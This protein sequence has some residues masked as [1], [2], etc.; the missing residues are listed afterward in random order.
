MNC[1]SFAYISYKREIVENGLKRKLMLVLAFVAVLGVIAISQKLSEYVASTQMKSEEIFV[2]VDAGHGAEDPGKIGINNVLE[3][4]IN[5]Q[6][7]KKVQYYLKKE[8][9]GVIMTREDDQGLYDNTVSNKKAA[10][11]K[12]RVNLINEAK[13]VLVVSIHQNSYT[14]EAVKGAQVFYYTHSKEGEALALLMQEA[15]RAFDS[16]NTR[17]AKANDTYYMLKKTEV[18]TIIVECGFL[19]NAQEAEKLTEDTYQEEVA[20]AICSG[21]IKWLDKSAE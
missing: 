19:S 16:T 3:K 2:V 14:D 17:Q 13:P 4:E 1:P 10:D 21:V 8:G 9:L 5:L 11:M 6:I 12:K 20:K 15:L 18:P 7:A